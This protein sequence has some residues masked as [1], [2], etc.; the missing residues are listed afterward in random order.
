MHEHW[1]PP[2]THE[3]ALACIAVALPGSEQF[4]LLKQRLQSWLC[5]ARRW[6]LLQWRTAV[7]WDG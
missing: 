5:R 7:M 6:C 1:Q 4:A 2:H 3:K